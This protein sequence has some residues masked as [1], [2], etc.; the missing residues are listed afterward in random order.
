MQMVGDNIWLI[1]APGCLVLGG[2][3][4]A[5]G[6]CQFL[7]MDGSCELGC[8]KGASRFPVHL[9]PNLLICHQHRMI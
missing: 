6:S 1:R 2:A 8:P 7:V 5:H 3:G 9:P 4:E